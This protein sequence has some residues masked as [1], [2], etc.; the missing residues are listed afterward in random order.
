[1]T[2]GE[3]AIY[4]AAKKQKLNTKSSM[5][6]E[7][8]AMDNAMPQILWTRYFF[9]AQGYE[10]KITSTFKIIKVQC[11]W[12][13][14]GTVSSS[15][16]TRH[17]DIRFFFVKDRIAQGQLKVEYCPTEKKIGVFFYQTF[18]RK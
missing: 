13:K 12:K 2:L 15:K 17:I 10:I 6:A 14:N 9:S 18:A 16:R 8:V 11:Y 5:E 3:G 1:M 7:L 4:A